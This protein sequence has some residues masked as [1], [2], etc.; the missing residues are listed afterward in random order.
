M[1]APAPGT[2]LDRPAT[3]RATTDFS[4]VGFEEAVARAEAL[5]PLLREHAELTERT[6]HMPEPVLEALHDSGLLRFQQPRVWGGMELDWPAFYDIPERLGRGCASTAWTFANLSSHHRQLA[7][8][9]LQAQEEIW[10][11]DRDA[12]IASGIAYVQGT[13]R[14]VDGG[15]LLTGRWGFSSGVD[16]SQWN[17]LACVVKDDEGKPI[18]WCSCLVPREDYEIIDDW[19]TLGMRGT[20]SRSVACS[21]VFVPDHRVLS[22]HVA[23]PGHE[24]PG[25]REHP[26]PLYRVPAAAL[27]GHAIAG[28]M[29]GNARAMLEESVAAVKARSTSYTGARM[30]DFA[31]VQLRIGMA[32]ARIDAADTWLRADTVRGWEMTRRGESMDTETKLRYKRNTA[33]AMKI[34]NEA[35]DMLHEMAGANGIYDHSPL[36]RMFRDAHASAGHFLFG[37]DAQLTPWGLVALGGE[38]KSPT[39]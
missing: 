23:R 27:G 2:P 7:Q 33:V 10:G 9:P 16:V 38:V 1:N 32:G 5:I 17:M 3:A 39:L 30:R 31:T 6:T 34:A 37:L 26:G 15:L 24:F 4:D 25:L 13:G 12:L 22:M 20:G 36:Q 35:V 19:Q 28:S 18:D 29:I 8:W 21:D 14:R 11:A